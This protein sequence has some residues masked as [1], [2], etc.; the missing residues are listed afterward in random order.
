MASPEKS[1]VV[2]DAQGR[3]LYTAVV[4]GALAGQRLA[5]PVVQTDRCEGVSC[6]GP[7]AKSQ[8]NFD[9]HRD[10]LVHA[11][12]SRSVSTFYP[13]SA[14][15]SA[16]SITSALPLGRSS[17][18]EFASEYVRASRE[19]S[20]AGR[21]VSDDECDS[22]DGGDGGEITAAGQSSLFIGDAIDDD[23]IFSEYR[24]G[25]RRRRSSRFGGGG[26]RGNPWWGY[27]QSRIPRGFGWYRR[28]GW[29]QYYYPG[30][31]YIWG[32]PTLANRLGLAIRNIGHGIGHGLGHLFGSFAED[33]H[34]GASE[35]YSESGLVPLIPY[36]PETLIDIGHKLFPE[37]YVHIDARMPN[38]ETLTDL[39][40]IRA[41]DKSA[42]LEELRALRAGNSVAKSCGYDIVP[43][44]DTEQYQWACCTSASENIKS[45]M[46]NV[47]SPEM[48][49]QQRTQMNGIFDRLEDRT[50]VATHKRD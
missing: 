46:I 24:H 8:G 48:S 13:S 22:D 25:G 28:P 33:N 50:S 1:I 6:A 10:G 20:S 30:Y 35:I 4:E 27:N 16:N 43:N 44:F 5:L 17:A 37:S 26:G 18:S 9:V 36:V 29:R 45:A 39:P 23:A 42:L 32:P 21:Y 19:I 41:A 40:N 7:M 3:Y 15:S 11:L 14:M 49:R 38:V 34:H 31:G 47:E 2:T 12:K